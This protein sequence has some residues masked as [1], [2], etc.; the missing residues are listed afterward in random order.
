MLKKGYGNDLKYSFYA[1]RVPAKPS[2]RLPLP[3]RHSGD[4]PHIV[5]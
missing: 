1:D 5:S 3:L 4:N 2:H